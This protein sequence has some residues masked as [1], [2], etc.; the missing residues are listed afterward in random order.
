MVTN[1]T[2]ENFAL[3]YDPVFVTTALV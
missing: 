1:E 2:L 3:S